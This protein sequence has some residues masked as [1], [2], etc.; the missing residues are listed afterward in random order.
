MSSKEG[1]GRWAINF[2]ID[3]KKA[4]QYH[5]SKTRQGAY[6]ELK[7]Y[8]EK[9]Q[10]EHRQH[11]GYVSKS[12]KQGE[13]IKVIVFK[14]LEKYPYVKEYVRHMDATLINPEYVY[15]CTKL[16]KY[17]NVRLIEM[18]DLGYSLDNE[19]KQGIKR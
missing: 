6:S 1:Q 7:N 9:E 3:T 8:F 16:F 12:E 17:S 13:E 14:L 2:D 4:E 11:S 10:F 15:D 19:Q 18:G 5:P